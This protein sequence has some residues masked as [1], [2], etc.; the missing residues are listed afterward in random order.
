MK[1]IVCALLII[2][3]VALGAFSLVAC[4]GDDTDKL[5]TIGYTLYEPMNYEENGVLVGFDTD[6]A[7]AVFEK[8]GYTVQFKLIDWNNKYVDL[9]AGT[10]DCLWNGFTANSA[11]D[12][13][14]QRSQKVDFSY[15]YMQNAQAVV[16]RTDSSIATASDLVGKI[17]YAEKGSAGESYANELL[18]GSGSVSTAT[19]QTDAIL[20]VRTGAA[21]YAVVDYQLANSMVGKGDFANL[22][23]V[24][25]LESE[26]EFYAIGFKKGSD[27]TAKV[28]G[29]L[30]ELA[31]DGTIKALAEKYGVANSVILDYSDQISC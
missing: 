23:M 15:N 30:V 25:A 13:G 9:N 3:V 31:A 11:D 5:V 16:V 1:K 8:L 17:G 6:L 27:L 4:N 21:D 28:N 14:I 29:A 12:D 24:S 10:V 18:S 2:S 26:S 22:K 20:Q 7:K 19:K